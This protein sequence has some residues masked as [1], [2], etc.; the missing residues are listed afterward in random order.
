MSKVTRRFAL[1]QADLDAG[2]CA[3]PEECVETLSGR[4]QIPLVLEHR[5]HGVT[6]GRQV[7]ATTLRQDVEW[8][9]TDLTWPADLRPGVLVTV[10]WQAAKDEVVVRTTPL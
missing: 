2:V 6:P 4:A 8:Q 1:W 5:D 9:F 7:F 3:A 10:S